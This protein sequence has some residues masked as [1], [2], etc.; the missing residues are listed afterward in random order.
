[1]KKILKIIFKIIRITLVVIII[2]L[3]VVPLL[4]KNKILQVVKNEANKSLNAKVEFSDIKIS[5][6]RNFPNLNVRLEEL[7]IVGID[8]FEKDTLVKFNYFSTNLKLGSVI[9]GKQI[10][11]N[12]IILDQPE[13]YIKV[14]HNGKANYDIV[15]VDSTKTDDPEPEEEDDEENEEDEKTSEPYVINL[16]KLQINNA[17]IIYDDKQIRIYSKLENLNFTLKGDLS[18][19]YTSIDLMLSID[20]VSLNS[21]G[22]QY[23]DRAKLIFESEIDADMVNEK[24]TFKDNLLQIN[25]LQFGFDGYVAMPDS[26][27]A[28]DISFETKQTAFKSVL[29]MI[30]AIYQKDF[31]DIKTDGIFSIAGH[32]EGIYNSKQIPAVSVDLSVKD[33]WFKYPD[34]PQSVTDINIK[35]HYENPGNIDINI[36]DVSEFRLN[37]AQNLINAKVYAKTSATDVYTS[38]NVDAKINLSSVDKFYPLDDMTL[39]GLFEMDLNFKGNLSDIENE[40]YQDFHTAGKILITNLETKQAGLPPINIKETELIFSPEI[41]NLKS[42]DAQIGKSDIHLNGKI[43]NIFQYIF[44]DEPLTANFN[45]SSGVFDVNDFLSYDETKPPEED[46]TEPIETPQDDNSEQITAFKIPENINF[47]LTTN[48]EKVFYEKLEIKKINGLIELANG[49]LSLTDLSM[50]LLKGSMRLTAI[51]DAK[52][53]QSPFAEF[54]YLFISLRF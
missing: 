29:S 30:P 23:V 19:D 4:F 1:M 16:K 20:S 36:I 14:L 33:A 11:I 40:N 6:F 46:E 34:L 53:I 15:K 38:G 47:T 45:F 43:F 9:F 3:A 28:M 50:N 31:E 18:E 26:N 32:V 24:Y 48:I 49:R 37:I 13:I 21:A 25:R 12:S 27:I 52:N 7:Y 42:F 51:Y 22:V 10:K 2:L 17:K 5:I 41:V 44:S 8:E 39:S 35:S 54:S